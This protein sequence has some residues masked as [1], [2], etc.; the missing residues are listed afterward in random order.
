[1]T[2]TLK[3]TSLLSV[4]ITV[5]L[6]HCLLQTHLVARGLAQDVKLG[7]KIAAL[8]TAYIRQIIINTGR[9]HKEKHNPDF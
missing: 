2:L 8:L 1:M 7:D 6:F 9:E 3:L 4:T 5:M